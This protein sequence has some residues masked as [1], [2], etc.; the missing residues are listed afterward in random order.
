MSHFLN[1]PSC[2]PLW[3]PLWLPCQVLYLIIYIV[4]LALIFDIIVY[5]I[6]PRFIKPQKEHASSKRDL[7]DKM[8]FGIQD[9]EKQFFLIKT[10]SF[11][12]TFKQY[13]KAVSR[14]KKVEA[15]LPQT[16]S[17]LS[18]AGEVKEILTKI[19]ALILTL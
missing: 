8:G 12:K 15:L 16:N 13:N 5:G 17:V 2:F 19:K 14:F 6:F 10:I 18:N 4:V 7:M 11:K 3:M 1:S 9:F